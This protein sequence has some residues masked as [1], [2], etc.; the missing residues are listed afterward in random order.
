MP[1]LILRQRTIFSDTNKNVCMRKENST[2]ALNERKLTDSCG[3][4]YTLNVIGGRWKP[5]ILHRLLEGKLRY[6]D[7]K[8]KLRDVSERMLTLQL[9]EL[10]QDGIIQRIVFA[11]VPPRVEYEL[12]QKGRSLEAM[13]RLM[14]K[15]GEENR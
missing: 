4:A 12:T 14:S 10:E 15:W 2:N 5:A 9:R 7:L 3:M 8:E 13:L 6:R 1:F 11:E